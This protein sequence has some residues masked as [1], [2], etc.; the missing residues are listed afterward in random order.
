MKRLMASVAALVVLAACGSGARP[1]TT[2]TPDEPAAQAVSL[3]P[4]PGVD[5]SRPSTTAPVD[6]LVAGINGAGFR[7]MRDQGAEGNLVLSP[8]SIGHALLMARAAA[9][10]PT[11]SA[12]DELFSLPDDRAAHEAWN[13]L[14]QALSGSADSQDEVVLSIADRV[15]PR[16]DVEP[17]QSWIDLL[18]AEHGASLEA[19]DY[20]GDPEGS[21]KII[22]DWVA[23]QTEDLIPEL[24]P[25][26]FIDP[27]T[28]LVLT[29]AIYFEAEWQRVFGKYDDEQGPFTRLDG[30]TTDVSFM[31]EL[32]LS[33]AR[34]EG[35]GFAGAEIPYVGGEFSMLLI[36]PDDGRYEEVRER[37]N[38]TF[39]EDV[40]A[41]FSTGPY[42]LF[43]PRWDD[44]TDLDLLS[45]LESHRVAPGSYPAIAPE[46]FLDGAV[47]GADI[48]VDEQGTVAAAATGLA[49]AESGPPDPEFTL[50]AD[51]PFFYVIRH[52]PSGAVLFSGQVTDPAG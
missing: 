8:L 16:S 4:S 19:L 40:D 38:H 25:E 41:S 18:A 47:H 29:D 12:I 33:D 28:L 52:R 32:E 13:A 49:F 44:H 39:L 6:E 22:N 34:G 51:R 7:L 48:S 21:R 50:R 15:W 30:S 5:R 23:V 10:G 46:A 45:W 35:E 31:H 27:N 37:L 11:G 26:G 20:V 3:E 9:D 2:S 42:E 14:D 43:L 24:L 1:S 17:E 36:V